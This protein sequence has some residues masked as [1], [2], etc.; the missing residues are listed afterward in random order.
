MATRVCVLDGEIPRIPKIPWTHFWPNATETRFDKLVLIWWT[1]KNTNK[2]IKWHCLLPI[3]MHPRQPRWKVRPMTWWRAMAWPESHTPRV[4]GYCWSRFCAL[5]S[6][7]GAQGP[8]TAQRLVPVVKPQPHQ[9]NPRI[10][11][12]S[13]TLKG[14]WLHPLGERQCEEWIPYQPGQT[15]QDSTI[16]SSLTAAVCLISAWLS[17]AMTMIKNYATV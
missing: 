1:N 11:P 4:V 2:K 6:R 8:T 16:L 12:E 14:A 10:F 7:V 9:E 17:W 15:L 5:Q 3:V 13:R